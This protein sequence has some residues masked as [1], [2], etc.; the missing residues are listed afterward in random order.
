MVNLNNIISKHFI[1]KA[2]A[3]RVTAL[4]M[5]PMRHTQRTFAQCLPGIFFHSPRSWLDPSTVHGDERQ[6]VARTVSA[7]GV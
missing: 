5:L 3:R 7:T 1:P 6:Q 2:R 4:P